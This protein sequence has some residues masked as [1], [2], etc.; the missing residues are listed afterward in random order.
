MTFPEGRPGATTS[1][2]TYDPAMLARLRDDT[3]SDGIPLVYMPG[4]D[5]TGE[6]MLGTAARLAERFRLVRLRYESTGKSFEGDGYRGLAA[7]AADGIRDRRIERT[8][9]VAESFGVAVAL[10]MAL[11]HP[12][13]VAGMLLVNGF[14]HFE[15]R[16][17]LALTRLGVRCVPRPLFDFGRRH[18]APAQLFGPRRDPEAERRFLE[19]VGH[20]FDDGYSRR[21]TMIARLDFRDRLKEIS[22]PINLVA[23][24]MDRIVPS[25]AAARFM[26]DKLPNASLEILHGGGHV[27]LALEDEPW[28]ERVTMLLVRTDL[29]PGNR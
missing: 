24:D 9:V 13:L 14:A 27:V 20:A 16:T 4:I 3:R 23:S 29:Q 2:S 25:V 26:R 15:W 21:L 22:Q 12:E 8:L 19:I 6:M 18:F 1:V 11:D 17:K 7:S 5:G 10:R 28:V